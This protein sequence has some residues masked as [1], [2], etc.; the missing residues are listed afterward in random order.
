MRGRYIQR[1]ND[2]QRLEA[3]VSAD[4]RRRVAFGRLNL[5]DSHYPVGEPMDLILCRNVLIYFEKAVQAKVVARLCDNL[6]PGGHL[7]LGHSET[8][9]GLD[10]PLE[11]VANTVFRRR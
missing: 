7:I 8:I 10:V 3:R 9:M 6:K 1:A 11:T 5:M 2:P 4:L